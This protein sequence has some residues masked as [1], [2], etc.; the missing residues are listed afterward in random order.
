MPKAFLEIACFNVQSAIIGYENGANRIELCMD[1]STEG[2]TPTIEMIEQVR[3]K[4]DIPLHVMIRPR[5]GSYVY[6]TQ[7]FEQIKREILTIKN[8]GVD[9]LVFGSLNSSGMVEVNQNAQW[10]E[11]AYPLPCTFHRAFDEITEMNKALESLIQC[12]FHT[13]LSSAGKKSA[14]DGA[15]ILQQLVIQANNKIIVMPGGGVRATHAKELQELT[16]AKWLHSSAITNG[17]EIAIAEEI[18]AIQA[19]LA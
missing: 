16:G 19:A 4:I 10:V 15:S 13:L 12:G 9:G 11:L 8:L 2:I 7:E 6:S 14:W 17:G 18:C 3:K 5:A 1:K